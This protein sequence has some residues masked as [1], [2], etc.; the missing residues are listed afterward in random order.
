[1]A[2]ATSTAQGN[3]ATTPVS[4]VYQGV[5][6][7]NTITFFGIPI[8]AP[9]TTGA[10]RTIRI[11]NARVNATS[12]SGGSAAGATPVI[13]SISISGATSLLIQN[14][15]PTVGFVQAGLSASASSATNQNQCNS[16]TRASI[17]TLSFAE[18]FGTAFKTRIA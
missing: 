1:V 16:T 10:T 18:N 13:A 4:N 17:N 9:V 7:G 5:V 2:V 14:P 15:T 12:L 6:S 8:L 3:T 11:T